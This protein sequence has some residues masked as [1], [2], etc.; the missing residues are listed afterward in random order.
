MGFSTLYAPHKGGVLV[1]AFDLLVELPTDAL[2][3][4]HLQTHWPSGVPAGFPVVMQ[5]WIDDP[6][7]PQGRSGSNAVGAL[8]P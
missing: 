3:E 7:A 8:T 1:P 6:E 4:I 2:G 5:F